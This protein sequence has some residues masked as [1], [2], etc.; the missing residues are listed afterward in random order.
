MS[1]MLLALPLLVGC[2]ATPHAPGSTDTLSRPAGDAPSDLPAG[3]R[4]V[5]LDDQSEARFVVYPAG[6]LARLGHPHVV[7]GPV[8]SGEIVLADDFHDSG[9]KL[10]IPVDDFEIDRPRWREDE[11]FDPDMSEAAI[12]GTRENLLGESQLDAANHPL[13]T[14]E[15]LGIKGPA[16]QPDIDV[17]ITLAG[18]ARELTV[19]VTLNFTDH[20]LSAVG[21]FVI[22][23]SDFDIE[24]FSAAGGNL[25]VADEVLIRFRIVAVAIDD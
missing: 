23:Q 2:Q 15:S 6:R 3:R 16:W 13:I 11:G 22:R 20:E 17:R 24:P 4:Y 9:L 5:V 12:E 10:E 18:T 21:R 8:I 1:L 7:G 25:Q 19:P 14:I